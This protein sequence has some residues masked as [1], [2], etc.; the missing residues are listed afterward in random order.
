[1]V[2]EGHRL[3]ERLRRVELEQPVLNREAVEDALWQHLSVVGA[4]TDSFT[5]VEDIEEG[6]SAVLSR[7]RSGD[8]LWHPSS[9]G[10]WRRFALWTPDAPV[11]YP[12]RGSERREDPIGTPIIR[13]SRASL[14]RRWRVQRTSRTHRRWRQS[15][16]GVD[17]PVSAYRLALA[18]TDEEALVREGR[19]ERGQFD[20]LPGHDTDGF[21]QL[22]AEAAWKTT[23]RTYESARCRLFALEPLVAAFERGLG[24]FWMVEHRRSRRRECFAVPRPTLRLQ[25]GRLHHAHGPA[26]EWPSG[27]SYWFLEGLPLSKRLVARTSGRAELQVLVRTRNVELRRLLLERLGHER[28]LEGAGA[29]LLAQDDFGRLWRTELEVDGEALVAVEVANST[30]ESDGSRK[31]Y[32]LRVPPETTSARDAVAWTFGFRNAADYFIAAES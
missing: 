18:A 17:D 8:Q 31:R 9:S 4:E 32:F 12:D 15:Y 11:S 29:R 3:S 10:S 1:M 5:W 14:G 24:F 26:V 25:D 22:R 20:P 30:P 16:A 19:P 28:F 27:V 23:V 2:S 13:A 7:L 21:A 6:F